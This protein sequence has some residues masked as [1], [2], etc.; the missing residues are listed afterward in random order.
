M[1]EEFCSPTTEIAEA[2][3]SVAQ[4]YGALDPAKDRAMRKELLGIVRILK[5]QL[6]GDT[7]TATLVVFDGQRGIKPAG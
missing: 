6:D 3:A 7:P 5:R 1:D 4:Q 2:I